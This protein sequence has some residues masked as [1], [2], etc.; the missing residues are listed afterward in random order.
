M[1]IVLADRQ[2]KLI[3]GWQ[4]VRGEKE[5]VITHHGSIFEVRCDA[6]VSSANSFGFIDSIR[7][8]L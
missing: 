1:K 2:G 7:Y 6:L 8:T 3:E 5:Y 4:T